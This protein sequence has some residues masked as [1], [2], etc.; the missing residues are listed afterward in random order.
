[1]GSNQL[2]DLKPEIKIKRSRRNIMAVVMP[3]HACP[4]CRDYTDIFEQVG[5][6]F[7]C[8]TCMDDVWDELARRALE[9]DDD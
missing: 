3:P 6:L 9:E 2:S 5:V 1:M 7:I 4:M 8:P